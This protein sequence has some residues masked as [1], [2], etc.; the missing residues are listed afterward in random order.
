M[1]SCTQRHGAPPPT[2]TQRRRHYADSF[3]ACGNVLC[4]CLD[5]QAAGGIVCFMHPPPQV[6][7]VLP[8]VVQLRFPRPFGPAGGRPCSLAPLRSAGRRPSSATK[9]L[10]CAQRHGAPPPTPTQPRQAPCGGLQ[11]VPKPLVFLFRPSSGGRDTSVSLA[12]APLGAA[13]V[14]PCGHLV[15]DRSALFQPRSC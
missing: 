6:R 4:F 2:P 9:T 7:Y 3:G 11:R 14:R 15:G 1:L 13:G 10:A 5:P 12:Y 8:S